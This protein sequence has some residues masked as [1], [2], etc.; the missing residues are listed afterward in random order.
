MGYDETLRDF[1]SF[2]NQ[3]EAQMLDEIRSIAIDHVDPTVKRPWE[4]YNKAALMRGFPKLEEVIMVLSDGEG[5]PGLENDMQLLEPRGNPEDLFRLWAE[6]KQTLVAEESVLEDIR[7]VLGR[8]YVKWTLPT[9]KI[10][11][12]TSKV[13][14]VEE[15]NGS[16]LAGSLS[17]I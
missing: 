2:M 12:K 10:R 3:E 8:D 9:V 7:R 1:R 15:R 14:R 17:R 16:S 13:T 11:V 5:N 6:F 4:A